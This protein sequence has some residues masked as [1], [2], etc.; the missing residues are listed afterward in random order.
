MSN[1]VNLNQFRKSSEKT[2]KRQKSQENR[3]NFGRSKAEKDL[4]R[5]E[6]RRSENEHD[7]KKLTPESPEET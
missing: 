3:E 7:S 1:V 6:S 4:T 2:K 5:A